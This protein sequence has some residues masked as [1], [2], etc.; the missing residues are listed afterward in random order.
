MNFDG[1]TFA[2]TVLIFI[3]VM[4]LFFGTKDIPVPLFPQN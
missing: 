4:L 2:Q 3:L 1:E